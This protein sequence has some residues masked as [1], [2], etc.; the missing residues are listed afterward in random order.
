[1]FVKI[2]KSRR[3]ADPG[4]PHLPQIDF[5]EGAVVEVS[6]AMGRS[7]IAN[8]DG[9][10]SVDNSRQR[11]VVQPESKDEGVVS[12]SKD[13]SKD[14]D[15]SDAL[16]KLSP[17]KRKFVEEYLVDSNETEAAIRAGYSESGAKKQGAKLL[18]DDDVKAAI[19]ECQQ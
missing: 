9:E 7:V 8:G 3:Y 19:A 17:K 1:M 15:T 13:E 6:D 16:S 5:V 10:E 2:K 14:E 4:G 12:E 18:E 11:A